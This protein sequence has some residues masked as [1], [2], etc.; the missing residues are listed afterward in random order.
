MGSNRRIQKSGDDNEGR[1]PVKRAGWRGGGDN[2][3]RDR[4]SKNLKVESFLAM[5]RPKM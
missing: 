3:V 4:K 2:K 1:V 5:T